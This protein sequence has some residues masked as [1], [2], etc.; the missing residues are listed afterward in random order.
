MTPS[1]PGRRLRPSV[2]SASVGANSERPLCSAD[3]EMGGLSGAKAKE[4]NR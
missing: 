3:L 4:R 1:N 2:R